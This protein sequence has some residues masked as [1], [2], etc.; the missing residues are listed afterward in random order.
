MPPP[1]QR[2]LKQLSVRRP[3]TSAGAA[4]SMVSGPPVSAGL[5]GRLTAALGMGRPEDVPG[6]LWLLAL[7]GLIQTF[8]ASFVWPINTVYIHFVLKAP[9]TVA[10]LVLMLNSGA[11]LAG[12]LVGGAAFDRVGAR[13]VI[14]AGLFTVAAMMTAI[15]FVRVWPVYVA[16]MILSGFAWGVMDPATN[17][18]VAR[19][20]PQGGRRG[21]NFLYV[22]RNAGVALGTAFGGLVAQVSFSLSFLSNAAAALI[23]GVMVWRRLPARV[24]P[25]PQPGDGGAASVPEAAGQQPARTPLAEGTEG[26][27]G[28]GLAAPPARQAAALPAIVAVALVM[29]GVALVWM[30][31]SQWQAVISVYMRKLGY[32][33]ASYSILWTLNGLLIV[34]G[35][36]LLTAV[37]RRW[38]PGLTGQMVGGALLFTLAFV[39]VWRHPR[40][41]G[42]VLGMAVLTLGEMLLFPALPAAVARVAPAGRQGLYQGILGGSVSAGRML[43][44]VGGGAMYDRWSPAGVL[45]AASAACLTATGCFWFYRAAA[46]RASRAG[47]AM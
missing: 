21:F 31:Y 41:E 35:Q 10:G 25:P 16:A 26:P 23:Y 37:V 2:P 19:A 36:P 29:L 22:A 47:K 34:A 27:P 40:Y 5:T 30:A 24:E 4:A 28:A 42:F 1:I 9:L 14:L 44:P 45:A 13:R 39:L 8:G 15:A 17:A 7:G 33:L 3:G 6:V 12:Q 20:W 43:G 46:R 11:A 38:I 32:P 18:L